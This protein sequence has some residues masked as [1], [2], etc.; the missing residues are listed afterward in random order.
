MACRRCS[1]TAELFASGRMGLE[2]PPPNS[3]PRGLRR[4]GPDERTRSRSSSWAVGLAGATAAMY[5]CAKRHLHQGLVAERF[6]GRLLDTLV[7]E[8]FASVSHTEGPETGPRSEFHVPEYDV[9]LMPAQR[10][11]TLHRADGVV[12][13]GLRRAT[14]RA[15]TVILATGAR[16][17][18]AT[19]PARRSTANKGVTF[20]PHC[21]GPLFKGSVAVIGGGNSGVGQPS[22]WLVLW[23]M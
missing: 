21:D 14:L 22:I 1:G 23:A 6:G 3:M 13:V 2:D 17:R 15:E 10:V 16:W 8:N 19:S 18:A 12:E 20:C 4:R 9:D 11:E 5:T 7:I